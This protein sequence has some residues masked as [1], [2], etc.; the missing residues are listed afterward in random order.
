MIH[1]IATV[2]LKP[3]CRDKFLNIL[4]ENVPRV[5]AEAGCLAYA[6]AVDL[7]SGLP[8]QAAIRENVVTL[9][10]AWENLDALLAHLKTP[11]MA[12]FRK[13]SK[14]YVVGMAVQVLKPV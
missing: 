12:D 7:D 9:V 8:V 4:R 2:E 6:P 13:A 1:V 14:D 11:H 3:N 10:E 5:K